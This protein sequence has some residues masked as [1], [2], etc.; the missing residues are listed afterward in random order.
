MCLLQVH[1][2]FVKTP[3]LLCPVPASRRGA[4]VH[5]RREQAKVGAV[6][7]AKPLT[8]TYLWQHPDEMAFYPGKGVFNH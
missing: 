1:N 4:T 8:L 6:C 7:C 5:R 3:E 2:H